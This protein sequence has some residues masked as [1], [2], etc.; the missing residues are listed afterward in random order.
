MA[1]EGLLLII[2]PGTQGPAMVNWLRVGKCSFN[3][4]AESASQLSSWSLT[5]LWVLGGSPAA[6]GSIEESEDLQQRQHLEWKGLSCRAH[7]SS[8][9]SAEND[10]SMMRV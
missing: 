3:C 7:V 10:A 4:Y 9:T 1:W 5:V 8:Q 6:G 2:V